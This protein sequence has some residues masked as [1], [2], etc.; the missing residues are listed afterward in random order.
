MAHF[1]NA[2][3]KLST[4]N[5]V[6]RENILH[7]LCLQQAYPETIEEVLETGNDVRDAGAPGRKS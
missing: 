4:Q 5:S 6:S 7:M 2:E 3:G 1:L